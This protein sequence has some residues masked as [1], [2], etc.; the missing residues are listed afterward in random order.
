MANITDQFVTS[1]SELYIGAKGITVYTVDGTV[2]NFFT[3]GGLL[4]VQ[5]Q[6]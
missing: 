6:K 3:G 1:F 2:K 5:H 4:V